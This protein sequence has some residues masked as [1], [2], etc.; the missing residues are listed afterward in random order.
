VLSPLQRRLRWARV[1]LRPAAGEQTLPLAEVPESVAIIMDGNGRWARERRLPIGAG[2]RA[3]AETL[4]KIVR[5]ASDRKV[6]YLTVYSFSTENWS[7]PEAEVIGLMDM[8][9]ELIDG[10]LDELHAEKVRMRFIGRRDQLS[11]ELQRQIA[12]SEQLTAGNDGMR[13]VVAMNY[14]GRNEIVDAARR[15]VA[16]CGPDAGEDEFGRLMYDPELRDPELVIRTSG[17]HRLSN[18]LLW[19]S[20]YSELYFSE[21]LWPQFTTDDFEE[22]LRSYAGRER[23]FGGR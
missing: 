20:A 10:E 11:H 21:R 17:E 7:R 15:F 3:G 14:G 9:V 8:F 12:R 16:E 2:H 23:R 13:F 18:F 5:Y 4:K 19:Q 6:G 22:A 1:L